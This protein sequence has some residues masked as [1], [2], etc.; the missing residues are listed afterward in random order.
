MLNET[1]D[2]LVAVHVMGWTLA[3]NGSMWYD[4]AE[5]PAM[6]RSVLLW[7][8][9]TRAD[10]AKQMRDKMRADGW[11]YQITGGI[12]PDGVNHFRAEFFILP[13][14]LETYFSAQSDTEEMAVA[15]AA[16]AAKGVTC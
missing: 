13:C 2:A 1:I 8:P 16:L 12:K 4:G 14:T 11:T 3:P 10:H 7:N 5:V 6:W 15:L 9:T